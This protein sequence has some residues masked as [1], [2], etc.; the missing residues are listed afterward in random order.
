MVAR[1]PA[2]TDE[3][4]RVAR[5]RAR[6]GRRISPAAAVRLEWLGD[7]GALA[8]AVGRPRDVRAMRRIERRILDSNGGTVEITGGEKQALR[9]V[10]RLLGDRGSDARKALGWI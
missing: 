9:R 3:R 5:Y 6:K 7:L 10:L 4:R 1:S 2:M 8:V